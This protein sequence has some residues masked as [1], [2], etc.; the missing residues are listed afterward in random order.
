MLAE[1]LVLATAGTACGWLI[2]SWASR[3]LIR[4]LSTPQNRIALDLSIDSHVLLFT[5]GVAIATVVLFGIAPAFKTSGVAPMD[6]LREHGQGAVG[7]ARVGVAGIPVVAQVAVSL[8]LMVAAAMFT[9][10]FVL[11]TSR[12]DGFRENEFRVD[13]T[14]SHCCDA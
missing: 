6:A 10:T 13:V 4:Q 2:A 1:A 14:P 3:L 7:A 9:R 11:L 12:H 8:V 5:I